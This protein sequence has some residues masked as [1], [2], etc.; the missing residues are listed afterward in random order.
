MRLSDLQIK[1][2]KEALED[3]MVMVVMRWC[4]HAK[5]GPG[6]LEYPSKRML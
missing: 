3:H 5:E 6:E 2:Q 4:L 1:L